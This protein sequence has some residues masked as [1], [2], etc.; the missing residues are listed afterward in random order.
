VFPSS[1]SNGAEEREEEEEEGGDEELEHSI[2][3]GSSKHSKYSGA[4]K[5]H[6]ILSHPP[7]KATNREGEHNT[8]S[9]AAAGGDAEKPEQPPTPSSSK[10]DQKAVAE[11]A[12]R[13]LEF[14]KAVEEAKDAHQPLRIFKLPAETMATNFLRDK[15]AIW[16]MKPL[17][18]AF[19]VIAF[20]AVLAVMAVGITKSST[21]FRLEDLT[22]DESYVR[23]HILTGQIIQNSYGAIMFR[24]GL[25]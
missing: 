17:V 16:M 24:S 4:S 18:K 7:T 22:P 25:V 23:A 3:F 13:L 14:N 2:S 8:S 1:G 5:V 11:E 21:E 10:E 19:I 20:S 12:R 15:L 6:P 9:A